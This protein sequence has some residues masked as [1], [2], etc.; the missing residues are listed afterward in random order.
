MSDPGAFSY[1]GDL[2]DLI[3]DLVVFTSVPRFTGSQ[4]YA[5]SHSSLHA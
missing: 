3:S 2:S 5:C 1:L 4:R